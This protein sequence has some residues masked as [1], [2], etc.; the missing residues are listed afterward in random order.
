MVRALVCDSHL[1]FG[2]SFAHALRSA[3]AAVT[4]TSHPDEALRA[5]SAMPAERVVMN[6]LFS[7]GNGLAA[8]RRIC[9]TWPRTHVS[10]LGAGTAQLRQAAVEAGAHAVLSKMRSLDEV[11]DAV[12]RGSLSTPR[13]DA[14]WVSPPVDA[15]VPTPRANNVADSAALA[16]KFLTNRERDVLRMLVSGHPTSRIADELGISATTARGYIQSI[17]EKL[18]VHSRVEAVSYAIRHSVVS[19]WR[20]ADAGEETMDDGVP[21]CGVATSRYPAIERVWAGGPPADTDTG[22]APPGITVLI[23]DGEQALAQ[24]VAEALIRDPAVAC[25]RAANTPRQAAITMDA[26]SVDVVVVATDCEKW[27]ALA[28]VADISRRRPQ[29]V[30]VAMSAAERP[31]KVAAAIEAGAL[32]WVSKR[33]PVREL[34]RVVVGA[35]RGDASLPPAILMHV[36][37][38]LTAGPRMR[39]DGDGLARLTTREQ[40]ILDYTARGLTR[41]EIAARLNVSVNTIRTHSQ[42][43]LS[44]LGVHTTLEAVTMVLHEQPIPSAATAQSA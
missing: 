18:G 5:L 22:L 19:Q 35:A 20:G 43:V 11:V 30:I 2:E 32:S 9:Q 7:E 26:E 23:V 24:A 21:A 25:A 31:E 4:V 13:Q 12:L 27:D 3:G 36:L 16:A 17:L 38:R 29:T 1:L 41:R 8:I 28:L 39:Q 6:A 10:C 33:A 37:R 34:A 42:N 44:K 15:R 14:L 40:Q